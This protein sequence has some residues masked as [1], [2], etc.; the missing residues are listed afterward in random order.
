MQVLVFFKRCASQNLDDKFVFDRLRSH[1]SVLDHLRRLCKA[2][3]DPI[4]HSLPEGISGWQD[5]SFDDLSER[6]TGHDGRGDALK[7]RSRLKKLV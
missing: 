7:M 1:A 2:S 4:R 5:Y 3:F 6:H